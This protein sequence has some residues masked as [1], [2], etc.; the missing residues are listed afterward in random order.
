MKPSFL[1]LTLIA[2]LVVCSPAAEP[3]SPI[4]KEAVRNAI[5]T[6]R[7]NPL[8]PEG[9]AAGELVR[10]FANKDTSVLVQI[11]PKGAPFIN[12][13]KMLTAERTLFMN[14]FIVGNVDSQLSHN[15]KKDDPYGGALEVIHVYR[16][17]QKRDP[18]LN[19]AGIENLIQLEKRG[20]LKNYVLVP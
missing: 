3:E 4:N 15:E 20:A 11:T 19:L 16:E 7:D 18:T 12:N 9:R 8:S 2:M 10:T 5:K 14:A 17:M 1:S 6:F 13:P